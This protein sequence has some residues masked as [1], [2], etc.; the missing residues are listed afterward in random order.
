M[1]F[2]KADFPVYLFYYEFHLNII[3]NSL[4]IGSIMIVMTSKWK[5]VVIRKDKNVLVKYLIVNISFLIY[6]LIM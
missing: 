1:F 4:F 2:S 6:T 3:K 5:S